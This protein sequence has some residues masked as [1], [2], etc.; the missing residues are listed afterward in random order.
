MSYNLDKLLLVLKPYEPFYY[1]VLA[2]NFIV[3]SVFGY[4][5]VSRKRRYE[6]QSLN[7]Q[8]EEQ[9][10]IIKNLLKEILDARKSKNLG[11]IDPQEVTDLQIKIQRIFDE[12]RTTQSTT[13]GNTAEIKASLANLFA[14]I[15][16]L[17]GPAQKPS[18][19]N[20]AQKPLEL[21]TVKPN[22][23]SD[24]QKE[25]RN[26][27]STIGDLSNIQTGLVNY[28][29]FLKI[30]T[31]D[32]TITIKKIILF[33]TPFSKRPIIQL[34]PV[35]L[36]ADH[37]RNVRY[38]ISVEAITLYQF[39]LVCKVWYNTIITGITIQWTALPG[40]FTDSYKFIK[41]PNSDPSNEIISKTIVFTNP[42]LHEHDENSF[43]IED[44][45][46]NPTSKKPATIIKKKVIKK[47][48]TQPDDE[49]LAEEFDEEFNEASNKAWINEINIDNIDNYMTI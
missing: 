49:E 45:D 43:M 11:P 26:L 5:L 3:G 22:N 29:N 44:I 39:T 9:V 2:I 8:T 10:E 41:D 46:N 21:A 18:G 28:T 33:H 23:N 24:I 34:S 42:H 30:N 13:L 16:G 7:P 38:N 20:P 12:W 4:Y 36:D 15:P 40:I 35:V 47:D 14:L 1:P 19:P 6:H 17:T 37:T 32:H 25:L 31:G 48:L 27:K